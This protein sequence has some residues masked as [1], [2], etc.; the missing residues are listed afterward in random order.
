M[1]AFILV[2]IFVAWAVIKIEKRQKEILIASEVRAERLEER[3]KLLEIQ[4]ED[5]EKMINDLSQRVIDLEERLSNVEQPYETSEL[6]R[7]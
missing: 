1:W 7:I 6:D 3:V 4:H 5:N 2:V